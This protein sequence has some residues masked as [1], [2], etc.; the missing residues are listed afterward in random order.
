MTN[1]PVIFISATS[2][3]RSARDLVGKVLFSMG[4]EPVW[5]DI[6]PTD[7][8]EL[9][10][11]LRRRIAPCAM[12]VQLVGQRYGAEPPQP[13]AAFGRASYTQFEALEA[14]RVAKKVIYH[15][16][17]ETFPTDAAAAEPPELTS[18]QTAYRQRLKDA[19][20]LRHGGIA[21]ATDLELSIRRISDDLAALRRQADRRHRHLLRLGVLGAVGI[22]AVAI[23]SIVV[24]NRQGR[25]AET[26]NRQTEI[27][28]TVEAKIDKE[29]AEMAKLRAAVAAAVSPKPLAAGRT[30][31]EPIPLDVLAKAKVLVERGNAEERVLGM[32]AL[33]QHAEA[34]R[35]IQELKS[36]PQ[37]PIDEAFRLLTMEGDN[38]YQA[39]EP[40]KAITPYEK[41][42]ALKPGDFR[43]RMDLVRVLT[44]ARL[45]NV[46]SNRHRAIKIAEETL[47]QP[48]RPAGRACRVNSPSRW[49]GFPLV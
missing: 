12:M 15:F 9:L 21:S 37:N 4:Y 45:G 38:W 23:V 16:L 8:G 13:T 36:K 10:E 43:A 42:L 32:I 27:A 2:D 49:P 26:V 7:G 35:L 14:E 24:L 20:R 30:Q 5:H 25:L 1:R 17:E 44:S 29:A 41:A 3:L 6:E 33:Q 28:N 46:A 48:V 11:V 47:L 19:N 18:L 40:D 22:A 39:R 34:D 31:P